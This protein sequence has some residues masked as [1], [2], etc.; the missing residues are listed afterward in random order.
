MWKTGQRERE[1]GDPDGKERVIV[2]YT[3]AT[4]HPAL[5]YSSV[6][7]I[8]NKLGPL[9]GQVDGEEETY[10]SATLTQGGERCV[11]GPTPGQPWKGGGV[12]ET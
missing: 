4:T 5:I 7:L 6:H 8:V 3:V 12:R 2:F 1:R 11:G 10:P 9:L